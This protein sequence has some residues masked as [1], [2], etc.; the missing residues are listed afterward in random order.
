MTAC[1]FDKANVS[2]AVSDC[3]PPPPECATGCDV[4]WMGDGYCD[5]ACDVVGCNYDAATPGGT[6]DCASAA[7][8]GD[9]LYCAPG[10]FGFWV[11]AAAVLHNL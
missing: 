6:S 9:T 7:S 10:C 1:H 3:A 2:G 5:P 4:S 11:R 8:G